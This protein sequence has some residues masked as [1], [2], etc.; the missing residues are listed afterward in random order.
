MVRHRYRYIGI[1]NYRVSVISAFVSATLDNGY[2]LGTIF[3]DKQNDSSLDNSGSD[4]LAYTSEWNFKNQQINYFDKDTHFTFNNS[5]HKRSY[6]KSG[7]TDLY[8]SNV[9]TFHVDNTK[10]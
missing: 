2:T 5:D 1:G 4:N 3:I 8:E 10:C 6:L 9:K 7:D